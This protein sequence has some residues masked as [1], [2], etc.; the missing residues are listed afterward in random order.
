MCDHHDPGSLQVVATMR[1]FSMGWG[2]PSRGDRGRWRKRAS[3]RAGTV[4]HH[5]QQTNEANNLTPTQ[6]PTYPHADQL[7]NLKSL[8]PCYLLLT[9]PLPSALSVCLCPLALAC[10]LPVRR[11]HLHLPAL[12][13]MPSRVVRISLLS[14]DSAL[15]TTTYPSHPL[16]AALAAWT[17]TPSPS[18][19]ARLAIGPMQ[20]M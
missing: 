3:L 14:L 8:L 1:L 9:C 13:A 7:L 20:R 16:L 4:A 2:G 10:A 6:I 12:L 5:P 18:D 17:R 19:R 15:R 11:A